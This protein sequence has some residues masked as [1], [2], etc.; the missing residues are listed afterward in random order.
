MQ[1]LALAAWC[2]PMITTDVA[3]LVALDLAAVLAALDSRQ[4]S[5]RQEQC[6][7]SNLAGPSPVQWVLTHA[8]RMSTSM[9]FFPSAGTWQI[10]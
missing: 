5:D 10:D 8:F 1:S 3:G 7:P 6:T 2:Q 4:P 9:P